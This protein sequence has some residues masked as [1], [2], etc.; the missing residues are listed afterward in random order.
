MRMPKKN[1]FK[2][3]QSTDLYYTL[4]IRLAGSIRAADPKDGEQKVHPFGLKK[5][6]YSFLLLVY[7]RLKSDSAITRKRDIGSLCV[8]FVLE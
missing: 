8:V 7:C 6:C 3:Y 4:V 1:L 2:P 5:N